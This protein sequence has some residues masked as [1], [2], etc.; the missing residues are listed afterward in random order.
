[1]GFD[2][3]H[4]VEEAGHKMTTM[5]VE[6]GEMCDAAASLLLSITDRNRDVVRVYVPPTLIV[7]ESVRSV[8]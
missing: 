2:D 3:L 5:R 1:M 6:K 8:R 7:R 4:Y